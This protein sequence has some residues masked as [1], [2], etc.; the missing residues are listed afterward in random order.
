MFVYLADV[1]CGSKNCPEWV[2]ISCSLLHAFLI[3]F[4]VCREMKSL[5]YCHVLCTLFHL[6]SALLH[7]WW[8]LVSYL[9]SK[10][11]KSLKKCLWLYLLR[12]V[13]GSLI[14]SCLKSQGSLSG[15]KH[16]MLVWLP[17][18]YATFCFMIPSPSTWWN[19]VKGAP[20][21]CSKH[22][23]FP[24]VKHFSHLM[25]L[26]IRRPGFISTAQVRNISSSCCV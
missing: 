18:L 20:T 19:H 21:F 12:V 14:L 2:N 25:L 7:C 6:H 8:S 16:W 3:Y 17:P 23:L 22:Y 11:N 1:P 5:V 9:V 4:C 24:C 10:H 26:Y 15:L 13:C